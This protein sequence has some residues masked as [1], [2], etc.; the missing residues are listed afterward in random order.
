[1]VL[2]I[3][4]ASAHSQTTSAPPCLSYEPAVV[5]LTGTLVRRTFPDPPN[6][7]SVRS[8]DRAETAWIIELTSPICV[9]ADPDEPG[10]NPAAEDV[11]S[12]QLVFGGDE[13]QEHHHLW[14]KKV[15]VTGT[16]F[17]AHTGHRR[18]LAK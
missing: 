12:V 1:M 13:I 6:Y 14:N 16:M 5:T 11:R 15:V 7:K 2:S 18:N 3:W 17:A 8:G 4:S 10:L 9:N